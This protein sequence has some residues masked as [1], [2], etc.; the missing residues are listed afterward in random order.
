VFTPFLLRRAFLCRKTGGWVHSIVFSGKNVK[1]EAIMT[2]CD[3]YYV[4]RCLD[5]HRDDFR[6]LV[7]R[8]QGAVMGYLVGRLGERAAA[9][10]AGQEA[11]V[12]AY[13]GLAKL[14]NRES[15]YPWLVGI[16]SLVA[17]EMARGEK[18]EKGM[19]ASRAAELGV[20]KRENNIYAVE[21]A[22]GRLP[23]NQ[24]DM[25]LLRYYGGFSCEEIGE[26]MGIPLGTV[27][28]T[29][30]RGYAGLREMLQNQDSK[31]REVQR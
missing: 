23:E 24:R 18:L 4:E 21:E 22:V 1:P 16:A 28:K 5:G 15:F 12:R 2:E 19:V 30:S 14:K 29:L 13:T 7:K 26:K 10:D 27:T 20:E 3:S 11:F 31:D 17:K 9:E 25:I 6:H 8:Y